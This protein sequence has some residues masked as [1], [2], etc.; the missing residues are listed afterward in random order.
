MIPLGC[1]SLFVDGALLGDLSIV[2]VAMSMFL[3]LSRFR[4]IIDLIEPVFLEIFLILLAGSFFF[5]STFLSLI[6]EGGWMIEIELSAR[7]SISPSCIF[8]LEETRE[9]FLSVE[10]LGT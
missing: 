9:E 1:L 4:L 8:L 2:M 5:D 6:A 3:L 10:S 7:P